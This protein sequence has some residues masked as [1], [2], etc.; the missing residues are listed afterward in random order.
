MKLYL[1]LSREK[2]LF[3]SCSI[4]ICEERLLW[5]PCVRVRTPVNWERISKRSGNPAELVTAVNVGHNIT[6]CSKEYEFS[7]SCVRQDRFRRTSH[8]RTYIYS[9]CKFSYRNKLTGNDW[10][11]Q[12]RLKLSP[13]RTRAIVYSSAMLTLGAKR[14]IGSDGFNLTRNCNK[15]QFVQS[16]ADILSI[17]NTVR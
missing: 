13:E 10:T 2:N 4:W 12:S 3:V 5:F 15:M 17:G 16:I 14:P 9:E 11:G 1:I 6:L 8:H 7:W